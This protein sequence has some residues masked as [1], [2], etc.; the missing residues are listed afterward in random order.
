LGIWANPAL[1]SN[2]EAAIEIREGPAPSGINRP[3][4]LHLHY[5]AWKDLSQELDSG[6]GFQPDRGLLGDIGHGRVPVISWV[7][8]G[9]VANSDRAIA[10]GNASE[11]AVITATAKVLA[12]YPGPILLRWFWGFN[13]LGNNQ[14]CRGDSWG[15]PTQQGYSDFIGAWQRIR[16]LFEAAGATNVVFLWNPGHYNADGDADDPHGLASIPTSALLPRRSP[17]ISGCSTAASA[18]VHTGTS[19]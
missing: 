8:D 14:S 15:T 12:Q 17:T 10:G 13:V 7:C 9:N 19:R 16:S 11:D 1:G 18:R 6:G 3:S 4:A 2:S 5:Y